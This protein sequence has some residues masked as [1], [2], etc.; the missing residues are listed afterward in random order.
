MPPIR[1][2]I[3]KGEGLGRASAGYGAA[4]YRREIAGLLSEQ[5]LRDS[6]V[7]AHMGRVMSQLGD[8]ALEALVRK[9]ARAYHEQV[10]QLQRRTPLVYPTDPIS[11]ATAGISRVSAYASIS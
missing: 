1:G 11:G 6:D 2:F 3:P 4:K 5:L 10:E 8:P 9:A 7:T